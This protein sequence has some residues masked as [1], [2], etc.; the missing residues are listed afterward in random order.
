MWVYRD[1]N[2]NGPNLTLSSG[3]RLYTCAYIY[4]YIRTRSPEKTIVL[5]KS[6]R[7]SAPLQSVLNILLG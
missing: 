4:I 1:G 3:L 5:E 2:D 6:T 7:S